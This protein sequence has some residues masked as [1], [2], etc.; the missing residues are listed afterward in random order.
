M[1]QWSVSTDQWF[2]VYANLFTRAKRH[3]PPYTTGTQYKL[4]V[5]AR[6][7]SMLLCCAEIICDSEALPFVC[8]VLSARESLASILFGWR[9]IVHLLTLFVWK[10]EELPSEVYT[11]FI[12]P[13]LS[14]Q[15]LENLRN[16]SPVLES[17]I[18]NYLNIYY[19]EECLDKVL[20]EQQ[21]LISKINK[22]ERGAPCR[23]K[24]EC[25]RK[26]LENVAEDSA[27]HDNVGCLSFALD[28][29][30]SGQSFSLAKLHEIASKSNS[31][32][33]VKYLSEDLEEKNL[34]YSLILAIQNGS[35]DVVEYLFGI[36]PLNE[37]TEQRVI[38]AGLRSGSMEIVLFLEDQGL[39][40]D[41]LYDATQSGNIEVVQYVLDSGHRYP[42]QIISSFLT[43][44]QAGYLDIAT[45]LSRFVSI[46]KEEQITGT[47][48]L[49]QK[50]HRKAG[51]LLENLLSSDD[52]RFVCAVRRQNIESAQ[53]MLSSASVS[54]LAKDIAYTLASEIYE[55]NRREMLRLLT[56]AGGST[57]YVLRLIVHQLLA[58]HC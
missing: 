32:N 2:R 18:S 25:L 20:E 15:D 48:L 11:E 28:S 54:P 22:A 52:L 14:V 27:R 35:I 33:V 10:M 17:Y 38:Q 58:L 4:N 30:A 53:A 43:A 41:S 5:L 37:D 49:L 56:K 3:N 23:S 34:R 1:H 6:D 31:L 21:S 51:E 7:D 57:T 36:L 39:E 45:L 50:S 40:L 44:C 47:W 55:E 26:A 19:S 16:V 8:M 42:S 29:G 13:N 24:Q 46:G 12:L 9:K